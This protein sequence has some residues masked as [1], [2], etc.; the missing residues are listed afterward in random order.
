MLT[1]ASYVSRAEEIELRFSLIEEYSVLITSEKQWF[2]SFI[3]A[4][5]LLGPKQTKTK[6]NMELV[7]LVSCNRIGQ[8]WVSGLITG[9][10]LKAWIITIK[11]S[12]RM[13]G[14]SATMFFTEHSVQL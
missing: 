12:P 8:F 9:R 10:L 14:A 7:E 11:I 3:F 6:N 13:I 2:H 5:H 4:S 1:V